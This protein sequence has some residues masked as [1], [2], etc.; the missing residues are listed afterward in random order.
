MYIYIYHLSIDTILPKKPYT[1][2]PA[3]IMVGSMLAW[4][5]GTGTHTSRHVSSCHVISC[6]GETK[7]Y[8]L[9][10]PFLPRIWL[11]RERTL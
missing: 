2:D 9:Y 7:S 1:K 4:R 5:D 6:P 10:V 11:C 8:F 3:K